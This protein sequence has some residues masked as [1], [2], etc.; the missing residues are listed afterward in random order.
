MRIL[1]TNDDGVFA[2]GIAALVSGLAAAWG[3]EHE[4]FVVAPLRDYS[5]TGAAVGPVYERESIPYQ[6]VEIPGLGD[7]PILGQFFRSKS[8]Q[9]SNS[10]LMVLCTVKRISPSNE[11]PAGPKQA[12]PYMD[13]AQ[14]DKSRK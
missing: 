6:A 10:E 7:I 13:P 8:L 1:I 4:L 12:Q 9:K 3:D 5:G 11:Q 14:F 2:P